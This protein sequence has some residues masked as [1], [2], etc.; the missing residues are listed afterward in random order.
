M[1]KKLIYVSGFVMAAVAVLAS[2]ALFN[3][4]DRHPGYQVDI[5][6]KA[7][8]PGVV[9]AGFAAVSITPEVIDTWIDVRGTRGSIPAKG[10]I[11]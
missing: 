10:I 11:S 3:M 9:R 4:R 2:I 6:I 1:R 7:S 5:D 8:S